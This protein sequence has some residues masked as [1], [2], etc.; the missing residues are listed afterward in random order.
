MKLKQNPF[1][2]SVQLDRRLELKLQG[3]D[4]QSYWQWRIVTILI[5]GLGVYSP[6]LILPT[7]RNA[8]RGVKRI[9]DPFIPSWSGF[10]SG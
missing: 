1:I 10:G 8:N 4:G 6:V 5:G 2:P 9:I 7:E 3:F